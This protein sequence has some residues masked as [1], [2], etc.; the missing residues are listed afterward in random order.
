M[1]VNWRKRKRSKCVRELATWIVGNRPPP[2][3]LEEFAEKPYGC[4]ILSNA[5]NPGIC[6]IKEIRRSFVVRRLTDS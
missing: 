6:G 2:L 4:V 5:K 3:A 1:V